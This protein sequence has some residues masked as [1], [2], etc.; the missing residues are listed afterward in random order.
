M[1]D[2]RANIQV[3]IPKRLEGDVMQEINRLGGA[4]T[5]IQEEPDHSTGIEA[6]IPREGMVAFQTWLKDF[7]NGQGR[8]SEIRD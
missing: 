7:S 3:I 2:R 5:K 6:S 8:S 4:I 1:P